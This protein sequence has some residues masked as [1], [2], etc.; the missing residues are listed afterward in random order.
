MDK[1]TWGSLLLLLG[2]LFII[3]SHGELDGPTSGR[4]LTEDE[5]DY[6]A[7]KCIDWLSDDHPY[8][9]SDGSNMCFEYEKGWNSTTLTI[10]IL[11]IIGGIACFFDFTQ[12]EAPASPSDTY[13]S[14]ETRDKLK[15][16]PILGNKIKEREE[17]LWKDKEKTVENKKIKRSVKEPIEERKTTEKND[18]LINE[19][20]KLNELKKEG[21]LDDEEFKAAKQKII[22]KL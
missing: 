21:I 16:I 2:L 20:K 12:N 3:G 17:Q 22:E 15:N 8:W 7:P 5:K 4:G 19:L 11:M 1:E 6:W 10:G 18:D 14:Q 13:V 9:F